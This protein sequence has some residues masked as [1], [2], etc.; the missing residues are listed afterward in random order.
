MKVYKNPTPT[1]DV[2]ITRESKILVIKRKKNPFKDQ[3]AI[4]GGF[5]NENET[6]EQAAVREIMEETTLPIRLTEILGVYSDPKRDPRKHIITVVF[7][8]EII[9][10]KNIEPIAGDDAAD[11]KWIPIGSIQDFNFAFDHKRILNDF[12]KWRYS[13]GTYWSTKHIT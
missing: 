2:I 9:G 11:T 4:P 8:G 3:L 10:D 13:R 5:V 6:V 7:V 12:V 1:A